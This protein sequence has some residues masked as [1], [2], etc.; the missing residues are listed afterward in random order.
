M[1]ASD[2]YS[3]NLVHFLLGLLKLLRVLEEVVEQE[4]ERSTCRF[5]S[6]GQKGYHLI[7]NLALE[8]SNW[9]KS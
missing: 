4:G 2:T 9:A 3:E 7:P 5:M 6:S 1:L 8:I